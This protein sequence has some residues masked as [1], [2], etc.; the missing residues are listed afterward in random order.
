METFLGGKP[1][2]NTD[3]SGV[4]TE[5]NSQVNPMFSRDRNT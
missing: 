3:I 2:Y 4:F 1:G 5:S